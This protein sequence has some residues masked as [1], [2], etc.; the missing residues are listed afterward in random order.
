MKTTRAAKP[1][2]FALTAAIAALVLSCDFGFLGGLESGGPDEALT[3]TVEPFAGGERLLW[4]R[5]DGTLA[6]YEDHYTESGRTVQLQRYAAD[7]TF[8]YGYLY[9]Y[10]GNGHKTLAAYYDA[11]SALRWYQAFMIQDGLIVASAEFDAAG[12]PQWGRRYE[13]GGGATAGKPLKSARFDAAGLLSGGAEYAYDLSGREELVTAYGESDAMGARALAPPAQLSAASA[14]RVARNLAAP[15]KLN[16]IMPSVPVGYAFPDMPANF[17]S[18][19]VAGYGYTFYDEH[20][21]S[22]VELRAD[23]YP[24]KVSRTDD[25]ID[26]AVAVEAAWDASNRLIGKKSWYGSTLAL[27]LSL[28]YDASGYPASLSASGAAMLL[29][30]RYDLSYAES[31][32]RV[33]VRLNVSSGGALLQYFT[34]R[35]EGLDGIVLP[36][37]PEEL[38]SLD[39]FAFL[40]GFAEAVVSI[41]HYDGDDT[42]IE[43]FSFSRDGSSLRVDV[44]DGAGALSGYYLASYDP[45]GRMASLGS[46]NAAGLE[47]WSNAFGYA[48]AVRLGELLGAQAAP[49]LERLGRLA[50]HYLGDGITSYAQAFVMDLL[51]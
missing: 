20:G 14:A 16:F 34:Y 45:D 26:R 32:V 5:S 1:V 51:F 22:Y 21:S 25:R 49:E 12:A 10:D 41:D 13:Y 3:L 46:Y 19:P 9:Q 37:N 33:P 47:L 42:L 2:L 29:P 30:L 18:L 40:D 31:G 4:S 35:Y 38:R 36:S 50:E 6:Y 23:W 43:T 17:A 7:G 8:R 39:P 24:L 44:K 28:S 11:A 27:E 48:D 15:L